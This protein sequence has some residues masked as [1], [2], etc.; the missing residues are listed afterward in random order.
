MTVPGARK[1]SDPAWM[2]AHG[3]AA[4]MSSGHHAPRGTT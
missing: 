1:P 4:R 3:Q 2:L